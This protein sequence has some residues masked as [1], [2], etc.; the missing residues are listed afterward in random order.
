MNKVSAAK[1]IFRDINAMYERLSKCENVE[2]IDLLRQL[3][4]INEELGD[5]VESMIRSNEYSKI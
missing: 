5:C 4:T 1:K 3:A 2:R